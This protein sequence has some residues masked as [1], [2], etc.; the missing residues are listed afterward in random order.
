MRERDEGSDVA[1]NGYIHTGSKSTTTSTSKY[2][3]IARHVKWCYSCDLLTWLLLFQS[4]LTF[5]HS[6]LWAFKSTRVI[7]TNQHMHKPH[8]RDG[9]GR[10]RHQVSIGSHCF[11]GVSVD[12]SQSEWVGGLETARSSEYA[13][14]AGR[15]WGSSRA[16]T[17]N[18]N[19]H[20]RKQ[21]YNNQHKYH[22]DWIAI[23]ILK[24]K[25]I[26]IKKKNYK[27]N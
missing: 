7:K 12:D 20:I 14:Y 4:R 25:N 8:T 18:V 6:I 22:F 11:T 17:L 16:E 23:Y 13:E 3:H 27:K 2:H 19:N 5:I 24:L 9:W 21:M 15:Q 10:S 1:T 26:Y